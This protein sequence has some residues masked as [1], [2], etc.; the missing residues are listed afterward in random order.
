MTK[1]AEATALLATLLIGAAAE[2]VAAAG[3]SA[4]VVDLENPLANPQPLQGYLRQADSPGP[5]PA[6]VLLHSCNG[7]WLRLDER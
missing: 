6:V 4:I 2:R 5:S 1:L 3:P 7:N